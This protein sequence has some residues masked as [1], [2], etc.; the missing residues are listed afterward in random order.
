MAFEERSAMSLKAEF[1]RPGGPSAVIEALGD[2]LNWA[3]R[4]FGAQPAPAACQ[5]R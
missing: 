3:C 1:V 4:R 5:A 2:R